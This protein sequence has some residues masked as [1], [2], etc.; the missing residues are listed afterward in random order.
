[1]PRI[2]VLGVD[3][4]LTRCGVGVVDVAPDR[5]ASLVHVGVVRSDPGDPIEKRLA[6]IAAGLR[7]VIDEHRPD[8]VAVERVFA[9][10]NRSTVMGTAQASGIALLLAGER[11][12]P[13][14]THTP[15]EVKAAI[16]GYGAADKRQVQTMVARILRLDELPK[17][18]DAADALALALC[19]A[20]RGGPVAL[21]D[22]PLTPAQRAWADAERLARR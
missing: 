11:G 9:Q 18:A 13:A 10:Q 7:A 22:A 5:S 3:P 12:L 19:H 17:P 15:T 20:W 1:M 6:L 8:V 2:R 16:T 21:R 14:A 4:G